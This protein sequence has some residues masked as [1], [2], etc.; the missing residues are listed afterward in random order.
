MVTLLLQKLEKNRMS[1][2]KTCFCSSKH[3]TTNSSNHVNVRKGVYPGF[4]KYPRV[5]AP[6]LCLPSS[7]DS[8]SVRRKPLSE[9]LFILLFSAIVPSVGLA[10]DY[11]LRS[12]T[13]SSERI[14]V[15]DLA[16][17][18]PATEERLLNEKLI[19]LE[20]DTGV[21]I[22]LLTANEAIDGKSVKKY[23]NLDQD[24]VLIYVDTRGGNILNFLPGE[25]V[26]ERLKDNFWFEL[27]S[28]YGNQFYV[29]EY[30]EDGAIITV[31]QAVETCLKKG[32]VCD[33]APG[34]GRDQ[35]ALSLILSIAG[36]FIAGA[37]ASTGGN[38]R[39]NIP[40]LFLFSPLWGILFG[41]FGVGPIVVREGWLSLDL[42]Q[43]TMAFL[44]SLGASFFLF[45]RMYS[46]ISSNDP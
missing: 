22:R 14:D 6:F 21:K 9:V 15:V 28:R 46:N 1:F 43:N 34:F 16:N 44:V 26:K 7:R 2:I 42:L 8:C 10:K 24:S 31:I 18:L 3:G 25:R 13:G 37:A 12:L 39:V 33:R 35:Y 19:H 38:H 32:G 29:E 17:S 23:W 11:E 27:Q 5:L 4:Y 45:Q 40:W 41:S 30:G 36:G 20:Q